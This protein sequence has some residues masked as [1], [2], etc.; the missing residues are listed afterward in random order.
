[1]ATNKKQITYNKVFGNELGKEVLSDLRV[2]CHAT[3]SLEQKDAGQAVDPNAML[4]LEGRRQVFMQI[5]NTM[6]I[7][8]EDI[9]DFET[10][11]D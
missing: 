2:F 1:M 5:I 3:M 8:Y 10:N 7:N 6:K 9:Y 4:I 11:Y